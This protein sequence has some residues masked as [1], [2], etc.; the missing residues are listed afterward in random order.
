VRFRPRR[1]IRRSRRL[2]TPRTLRPPVSLSRRA[3]A[4][5]PARAPISKLATEHRTTGEQPGARFGL[6]LSI[7]SL[8]V[9]GLFVTLLVRLWSL[10]IVEGKNLD[11]QAKDLTTRTVSVTPPRGEIVA[12]SGQVLAGEV[13]TEEITL[14]QEAA[15]A[16]K[17]VV[18]RLAALLNIPASQITDDLKSSQFSPYTPVPIAE[19]VS[20][21]TV[22]A[23][24]ASPSEFP[25]VSAT[26][27]Y[28]R[29]YPY[30][31]LAA[32]TIG[33][34]HPISSTEL[35]TY[36][37][38]GYTQG[39]LFGQTGLESQY[40]LD[41]RG[42]DGTEQLQVNP[43]DQVVSSKTTESAVPGDNVVL[44]MDLPLDQVVTN[45]LNTGI[46]TVRGTGVAA[47]WGAAIVMDANTGAVLALASDPSYNNNEWATGG[48]SSA[49]YA[50]LQNN[51]A[52]PLNN[53]P[54]AGLQPPGSTFKLATATA[55]LD[56]GLITPY[57]EIDDTGS[58]PLPGQP[59][60]TD[61]DNEALG[62]VNVVSA[63]SESSDVF[64]YTLG[65]RFY[66]DSAQYGNTP[67]QSKAWL[68]G[69][70]STT[71][72]DLPG[73]DPYD[74]GQVDGPA[75][76]KPWYLGDN[77]EMAFGQ[78]ATLV[79][80]LEEAIAY[81]TFANGGTRYAPELA[82]GIVSSSGK[83]V[84]RYTPKVMDHVTYTPGTYA[85]LLSG[86][87]GTVQTPTGT[88]YAPFQGF[89]F[90]K[91]DLAGKTGT[92]SVIKNDT[93]PPTSWFV[94][95]GGPRSSSTR[96]V[97]VVEI[98][99]AGFGA[100]ASAPIARQI[101]NYLYAHPVPPVKLPAARR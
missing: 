38:Y 56:D 73:V 39:D 61:S 59:P 45:A 55:A 53:Y 35:Q 77:V 44:N 32:Q 65:G 37:K 63:I 7:S 27:E 9:I 78:G 43:Y 17:G 33:Y 95:F 1:R 69:F 18:P 54:V 42:T 96:Y 58:Y 11:V 5:R 15:D 49:N 16:N 76:T 25:G 91:W 60:L 19:G 52:D 6:R 71:G 3:P 57:T 10:Q 40:E 100:Q 23:I 67:I 21:Q 101:F 83:L 84:K 86:F 81:S 70:G 48:I 99:Q 89:N 28:V 24:S 75:I 97:V 64:F 93:I 80:P 90:T 26:S 98:N 51:P 22:F 50:A 87:E 8:V 94:G 41:L 79:T 62:W 31:A 66:D 88:A 4:P 85:A 46:D 14:S 36:A 20:P 12:R 2:F 92:A 29:T 47:P 30:N 34:L 82:A 68:Y 72:I 74:D 13:Q